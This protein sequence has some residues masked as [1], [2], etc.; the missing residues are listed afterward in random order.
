[1]PRLP[2]DGKKV[3]EYRVT[4]GTY[5][6]ERL[7][8]L[9][10]AIQV[11]NI[12]TP[13]VDI[14]KDVS[15][16]A[17][18][19]I[20]LSELFGFD[21]EIPEIVDDAGDLVKAWLQQQAAAMEAQE[22]AAAPGRATSLTGGIRNLLYGLIRPFV[23]AAEGGI[24]VDLSGPIYTPPSDPNYQGEDAVFVDSTGVP[25]DPGLSN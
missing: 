1:M 19:L 14:M 9:V 16:T 8:Q 24:E 6:R 4:L 20:I 18:L 10:T 25:I 3:I 5:E 22:S 13:I 17:T 7:D 15:A 21:F 11:K 2:V 12:S 23:V